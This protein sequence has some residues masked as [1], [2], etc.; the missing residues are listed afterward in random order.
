MASK[1]FWRFGPK[2]EQS[3][4]DDMS[5]DAAELLH[6]ALRLPVEPRAAL[7]DPLPGGLDR[8]GNADAEAAWQVNHQSTTA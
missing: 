2:R 1:I 7:A 5:R 8:E 3:Q 4:H 6:E